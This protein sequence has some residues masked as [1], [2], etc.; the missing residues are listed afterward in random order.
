MSLFTHQIETQIHIR[1]SPQQVWSVLTDFASYPEWNPFV[2]SIAGEL[3]QGG[4]LN[5]QVQPVGG[6]AMRFRPQ[7][8]TV[9]PQ[10][11][12]VWRGRFLMPGVFD[13]E[14]SFL[15]EPNTEGVTLIHRE[16]FSGLLVPLLRRSLEQGTRQGFEA[17]N[18][19]LCKRAE[20]V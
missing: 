18:E 13:G 5:V 2:Q 8:L 19:A 15:L 1:V 14:H 11:A 4:L 12:L 3:K 7:L 6:S 17:M 20:S 16:R 9:Q 10:R